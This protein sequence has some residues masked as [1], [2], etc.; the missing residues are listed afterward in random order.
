[1]CFRNPA[2]SHAQPLSH[3]RVK[4]ASSS[5]LPEFGYDVYESKCVYS[6]PSDVCR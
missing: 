6:S 3:A 1:M 5:Q 4:A 2:T